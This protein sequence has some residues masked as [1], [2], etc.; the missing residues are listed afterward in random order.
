MKHNYEHY[1]IYGKQTNKIAET[2]TTL[3]I[4]L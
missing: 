2:A 3:K 4:T 1:F